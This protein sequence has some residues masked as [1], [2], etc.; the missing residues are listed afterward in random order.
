MAGFEEAL[1]ERDDSRWSK[2]PFA[3]LGA[4]RI[5]QHK[6]RYA[7]PLERKKTLSFSYGH[8]APPVISHYLSSILPIF[9]PFQPHYSVL[10]ASAGCICPMRHA[11]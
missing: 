9:L 2:L 4:M 8:I 11:G 6:L 7:A 1:L 10:N 3:D 5:T